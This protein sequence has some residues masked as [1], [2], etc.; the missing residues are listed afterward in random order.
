MELVMIR[1]QAPILWNSTAP[2]PNL[3]A[4]AVLLFAIGARRHVEKWRTK[5]WC[6]Y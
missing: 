5:P 4:T 1:V 3:G 2:H 6:E